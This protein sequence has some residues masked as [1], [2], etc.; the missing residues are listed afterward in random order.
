MEG[1]NCVKMKTTRIF[2]FDFI[3]DLSLDELA[4]LVISD[5]MGGKV[6]ITNFVTPNAHG[7]NIISKY[8]VMKESWKVARYVLPDGQP[9]VW[10]S[11]FTASKIKGRLTGSDFFRVVFPKIKNPI[12][13][14]L[15]VVT[16][17]N[18]KSYFVKEKPEATYFIPGF[19]KMEEEEKIQSFGEEMFNLI[20]KNELRF[21]FIGI[22]DPKQ[23]ALT[24]DVTR[25][26]HAINYDKPCVFFFLGAS[27]EFYFGLKKR[28]PVVFQKMGLE[29]FYRLATE[30]RRMFRRYVIG[31]V[32]FMGRALFWILF[33]KG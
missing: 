15:F 10:L 1:F 8:P 21:V 13:K 30:P 18:L 28:A 27:F 26:L 23:S 9:I 32:E 6:G 33:R 7:I 20:V 19:F 3:C 5:V 11:F 22:S 16:N 25:R 2:G 14:S 12:Y 31:N 4:D 17:E 29:W 24:M